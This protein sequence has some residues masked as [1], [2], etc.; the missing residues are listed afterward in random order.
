MKA[1]RSLSVGRGFVVEEKVANDAQANNY[2]SGN[3]HFLRIGH[4]VVFSSQTLGETAW[5]SPSG[6]LAVV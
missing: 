5:K 4:R 3:A 1:I 6:W 2:R